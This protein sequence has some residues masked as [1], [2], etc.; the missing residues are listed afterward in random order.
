MGYHSAVD[1]AKVIGS[2]TKEKFEEA[3]LGEKFSKVGT[4]IATGTVAAGTYVYGKSK[5]AA[6]VIA[7]KGKEFSVS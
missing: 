6:T 7:D 5:D 3:K 2:K 1:T 4:A